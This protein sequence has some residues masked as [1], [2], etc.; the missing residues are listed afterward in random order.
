[1]SFTFDDFI[2]KFSLFF[3]NLIDV[4]FKFDG[5][6]FHF[7]ELFNELRLKV[8]VFV[9]KF[10]LFVA[11]YGNGVIK[12]VHFLL[13]SFEVDF[14]FLDFLFKGSVVIVESGLLLLHDCFLVLQILNSVFEFFKLVVL[15]HQDCLFLDPFSV[16][17]VTVLLEFFG[18][19]DKI[20]MLILQR[21]LSFII[22]LGHKLIMKFIQSTDF[23]LLL[24]VDIMSLPDLDFVSDYQIFFLILF[25]E[26][27]ILFLFK[28]L[29][30]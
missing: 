11:V 25:G 7:F 29:D 13:E 16:K 26:G 6:S 3:S 27:F 15:V 30:L 14:D 23:M 28:Q 17:F 9:L 8:N 21:I 24:F 4:D 18:L 20:D 12:F 2:H 19:P 5:L 1:M 10:G 22:G